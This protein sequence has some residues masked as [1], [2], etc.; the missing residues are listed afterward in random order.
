MLPGIPFYE[1]F[2]YSLLDRYR[3]IRQSTLV[4]IPHGPAFAEV[5]GTSGRAVEFRV[6]AVDG[7]E[8]IGTGTHARAVIELDR[9]N[10]R[11]ARK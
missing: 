1:R 10:D 4:L 3:F 7:T 5:T 8:E 11:L 9:F 2:I 6:R